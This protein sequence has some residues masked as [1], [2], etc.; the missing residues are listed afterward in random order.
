MN[1]T[2]K[3]Q[4]ETRGEALP[5]EAKQN[6]IQ[7]GTLQQL[8]VTGLNE[9]Q[10]EQLRMKHAEGMIALNHKAQEMQMDVG[11][12][13]AALGTMASNVRQVSEAGDAITVTHVQKNSIGQTEVIMG[14]TEAAAKGKISRAARGE[15]DRTL[16]YVII[17]A[18]VIIVIALAIGK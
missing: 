10:I 8:D 5:V 14:N 17:A 6:K 3:N 9:N 1:D 16:W 15:S 7:L 18:V 2:T 12:T 11:A 4:L 13:S